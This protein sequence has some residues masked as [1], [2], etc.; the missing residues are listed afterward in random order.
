MRTWTRCLI[1]LLS[2]GSAAWSQDKRA[3][4]GTEKAV[5]ALEPQW[6]QSQKANNPD[7]VGP[8]L[9]DTFTGTDSEGKVRGK[10]ESLANAKATKL[11]VSITTTWK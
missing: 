5:A 2:L 4:A 11:T 10:A 1:G 9:A 3:G 6:L 7:L 8:L